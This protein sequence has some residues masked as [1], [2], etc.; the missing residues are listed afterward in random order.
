LRSRV[1]RIGRKER[2]KK[3]LGEGN[4]ESKLMKQVHKGTVKG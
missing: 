3:G 1:G 4:I 2:E